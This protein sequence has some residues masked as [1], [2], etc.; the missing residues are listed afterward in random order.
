MLYR[1]LRGNLQP[2]FKEIFMRYLIDVYLSNLAS[3]NNSASKSFIICNSGTGR[4]VNRQF[5]H[6]EASTMR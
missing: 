4:R 5:S 2:D 3:R 6:I 1:Y